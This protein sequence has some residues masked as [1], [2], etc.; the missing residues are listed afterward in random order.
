MI[1]NVFNQFKIILI[2]FDEIIILKSFSLKR[3]AFYF[4]VIIMY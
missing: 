3:K 4:N 1:S 2:D